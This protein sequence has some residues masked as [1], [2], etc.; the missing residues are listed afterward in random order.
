VLNSL[1]CASRKAGTLIAILHMRPI[2]TPVF[3]ESCSPRQ[4]LTATHT[5]TGGHIPPRDSEQNPSHQM[6]FYAARSAFLP[7]E[8]L[9]DRGQRMGPIQGLD[10]DSGR[11][12]SSMRTVPALLR[13]E[14]AGL[15]NDDGTHTNRL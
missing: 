2:R 14:H 9:L 12:E 6:A 15:T 4:L 3:Y 13:E 1:Y 7:P 8:A 11:S 10:I 5:C